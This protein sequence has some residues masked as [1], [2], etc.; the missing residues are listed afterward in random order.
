MEKNLKQKIMREFGNEV[1]NIQKMDD[2]LTNLVRSTYINPRED[3]WSYFLFLRRW[4]S[5]YP[6]FYD[7][8][9]GCYVINHINSYTI[10]DPGYK[11][12]YVLQKHRI[13]TR[14]I[15]NIIITHNHLDHIGGV[16][17]LLDLLFRQKSSKV[18][19]LFVNPGMKKMFKHFE[20]KDNYLKIIQIKSNKKIILDNLLSFKAYEVPH[21]GIGKM[22]KSLALI[23]ELIVKEKAYKFGITGDL[24][25]EEKYMQLYKK[26][27]TDL[28]FLVLHLG[29]MK[30]KSED[31]KINSIDK[32]LYID[33]AYKLI[34]N[35]KNVKA[36]FLQEFGLEMANPEYISEKINSLIL[37]NG[38]YFPYL[39][40]SFH[41]KEKNEIIQNH[42][43]FRLFFNYCNKLRKDKEFPKYLLEFC[44][45]L[46]LDFLNS[47]ENYLK[48]LNFWKNP[49]FISSYIN[50]D[51]INNIIDDILFDFKETIYL[52]IKKFRIKKFF[53]LIQIFNDNLTE[54]K[55]LETIDKNIE[56][57]VPFFSNNEKTLLESVLNKIRHVKPSLFGLYD[58]LMNPMAFRIDN[59]K[60]QHDHLNDTQM[61]KLQL[62]PFLRLLFKLYS[63]K[64]EFNTHSDKKIA[65]NDLRKKLVVFYKRNIK[66]QNIFL[67]E[68]GKKLTFSLISDDD[69]RCRGCGKKYRNSKDG[70]Q[71]EDSFCPECLYRDS[72]L[73]EH[74]IYGK[75]INEEE[76]AELNELEDKMRRRDDKKRKYSKKVRECIFQLIIHNEFQKANDLIRN[77][78]VFY[79]I[80]GIFSLKESVFDKLIENLSDKYANLIL[81]KIL[82]NS[83]YFEVENFNLYLK[84]LKYYFIFFNKVIEEC[85]IVSIKK[86]KELFPRIRKKI[87]MH[88][89]SASPLKENKFTKKA[90]DSL[91]KKLF[92]KLLEQ[93][94]E[95][96]LQSEICECL[97]KSL[98]KIYDKSDNDLKIELRFIFYSHSSRPQN[99]EELKILNRYFF[100]PNIWL[101][102]KPDKIKHVFLEILNQ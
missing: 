5:F 20:T 13:D 7:V 46:C 32:H 52:G 98:A 72:I 80:F 94:N 64:L 59:I 38:Y 34:E 57:L 78:R 35:L 82:F 18:C 9:G 29:S 68:Y 91:I 87:I 25:G 54:T 50:S 40:L 83:I 93:A 61:E 41:F 60:N 23:F 55:F 69:L 8:I 49:Q 21:K 66:D 1:N 36:F 43:L 44:H 3:L 19:R 10:I 11:T 39:I 85:S 33:G 51:E 76:L 42:L 26:I 48:F 70:T 30:F 75:E 65:K 17:E 16:L 28:E 88:N 37:N 86:F 99:N 24:D 71:F 102:E 2:F 79:D 45:V 90:W 92:L 74:R 58:D 4:N 67:G 6:S 89:L 22:Q 27:F 56:Y 84:C 73:E 12:L 62:Y 96:L 81:K 31:D 53:R 14:N 100:P 101:K 15:Q 47:N 77:R 97:Y 95:N 63:N